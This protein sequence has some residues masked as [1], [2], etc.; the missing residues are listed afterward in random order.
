[1][2]KYREWTFNVKNQLFLT[3]SHPTLPP[4]PF[5]S[6]NQFSYHKMIQQFTKPMNITIHIT[7]T[8]EYS[9]HHTIHKISPNS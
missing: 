8:N 9:I 1:M 3:I 4:P 2:G 5:P 6:T 7:R